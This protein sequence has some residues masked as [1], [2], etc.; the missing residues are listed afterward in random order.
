M[1]PDDLPDLT[2][3]ELRELAA[4]KG[5]TKAAKLTKGE[6]V[7][8]LK[9]LLKTASRVA[10]AKEKAK[11]IEKVAEK[12]KATTKT[13]GR[14]KAVVRATKKISAKAPAKPV[15]KRTQKKASFTAPRSR[16]A[17]TTVTGRALKP[18]AAPVV[19][20]APVTSSSNAARPAPKPTQVKGPDPGLPVPDRYG[21][22]RL[23][24]MVQDP[25]H[26]F[27]YWELT[28]ATLDRAR[29]AAG[30]AGTPV[31]AI[32]VGGNTEYREVDLRG[33]NYYLA[34]APDRDYTA[35]LALRDPQGRL[36]VLARS[37]SVAT[38]APGVS[39]HVDEQWMG[40]DET[41]HELLELAGLPGKAGGMSSGAGSAAR[42]S[43]QRLAASS[44]QK[45]GVSTLSSASL[46][47]TA[48]SSGARLKPTKPHKT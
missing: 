35:E 44:W 1:K 17:P 25:H 13:S 14:V 32:S 30:G 24:L 11:E 8:A 20:T 18:P 43:D 4:A 26:L 47:S 45:G 19:S 36:H 7:S 3:K 37:N 48:L 27:A 10:K 40:V 34:V 9:P 16:R 6:L 46:S 21:R 23:V 15:T 5:V 28:P 33:G 12:A 38:P 2:V 29:S 42:L 41:F 22:D 39:T 31:L